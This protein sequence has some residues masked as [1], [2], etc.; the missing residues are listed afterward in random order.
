MGT[1]TSCTTRG[2][3]VIVKGT[4]HT[5]RIKNSSNF[6]DFCKIDVLVASCGKTRDDMRVHSSG[7]DET[8]QEI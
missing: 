7:K 5:N 2:T 3:D 4:I 1:L 6:R 8:F